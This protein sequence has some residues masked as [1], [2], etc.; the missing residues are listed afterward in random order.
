MNLFLGRSIQ[1]TKHKNAASNSVKG[2][3]H[4]EID[5]RFHVVKIVV[6]IVANCS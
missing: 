1:I 2:C 6:C 3:G 4:K 5:Q